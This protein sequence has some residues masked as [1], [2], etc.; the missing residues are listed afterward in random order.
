MTDQE[1]PEGLMLAIANA[2]DDALRW[3]VAAACVEVGRALLLEGLESTMTDQERALAYR[4]IW[5]WTT[6]GEVMARYLAIGLKMT[7]QI[8]D[9]DLLMITRSSWPQVAAAMPP[10]E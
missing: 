10:K 3:R 7:P 5:D 4:A 8:K 6:V 1:A 9:D 2:H